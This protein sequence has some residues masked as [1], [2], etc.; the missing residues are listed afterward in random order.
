[1]VTYPE[2]LQGI[3]GSCVV[4]PCTLSY[5]ASV[6]A[7]DGVV[8][9]WYKDYEGRK[10]VVY[11]SAGGEVDAGFRG[12]A[13]LLGDPNARNCTLLL[14]G[15]T[16]EDSGSYRFRFEI[17]NGDRWSA[18]R[19]V[20][21]SVSDELERP[22]VAASEE[23]TEGQTST[24]GCSTPYVCPLGD[25]VLRWEGYDPH[26]STVSGRVQLDTSGV[27]HHLTLT[28]SFSWKDHS[29][30]LLCEVSYGSRRATSVVVLR[31]RHSPKDAQVLV[32]PSAQ[33]THPGDTVSLT[34]EVSSSYPPISG[35]YWYKDGV[36]V[37][38]EK[39]LTLR[40]VRRED[41]GQYRCEAKNA[42]GVGVA[43]AV[44]LHV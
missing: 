42:V 41:Y 34:C 18:A 6:T 16:P 33:N 28:T 2:S 4:I 37:G 23:Q 43:P 24:L 44:T 31:V 26:V 9:I 29:K 8:A 27:G 38:T 19:D 17:V 25:V 32:S 21:L 12:R 7:G 20:T 35:Y 39:I 5:P 36:P 40:D 14:R 30:K 10:A 3:E 11:H 13:Q 22:S 1:G 15:V